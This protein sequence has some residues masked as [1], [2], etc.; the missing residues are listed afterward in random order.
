[1][2]TPNNPQPEKKPGAKPEGDGKKPP[3]K[4][5]AK[6]PDGKKPAGGPK[7]P[8]PKAAPVR[9][10]QA[11]HGGGRRIGQV[12]IDL[13]YID[14]DQLWEILEEARTNNQLT[15]QT[16]VARGL[17]TEEQLLT[18]LADQHNLKVVNLD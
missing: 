2:A 8:M 16:A 1:M 15:G 14:E 3:A 7:K 9:Q 13:G 4:P 17:I 12:L 5:A 6:S 18:A 10:A 11:A